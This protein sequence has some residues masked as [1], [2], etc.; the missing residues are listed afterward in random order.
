MVERRVSRKLKGNAPN[1]CV[2]S[3]R[4]YAGSTWT[5]SERICKAFQRLFYSKFKDMG[6]EVRQRKHLTYMN[7]CMCKSRA[8]RE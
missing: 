5:N 2:K 4:E 7:Q 3:A 6:L 1:Y 8:Y